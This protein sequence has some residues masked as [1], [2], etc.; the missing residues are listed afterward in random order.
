M[1]NDEVVLLPDRQMDVLLLLAERAGQMVSKETLIETAWEGLAVTDN[2][3]SQAVSGLR[4]ALGCQ[5]DGAPYI[6]TRYARG[7]KLTAPVEIVPANVAD[8]GSVHDD[9]RNEIQR[10]INI[11]ASLEPY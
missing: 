8:L 2:S 11:D 7:Y 6:D 4:K 3:I 1:R 9:E 10:E 5:P